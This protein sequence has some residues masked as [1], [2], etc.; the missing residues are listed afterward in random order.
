[1]NFIK[2]TVLGLIAAVALSANASQAGEGAPVRGDGSRAR[3][4]GTS[5]HQ[6]QNLGTS[7][8]ALAAWSDIGPAPQNISIEGMPVNEVAKSLATTF[9]NQFDLIL[10]PDDPETSA[11]TVQMRLKDAP[12]AE[13]F[14]AMNL[15]FQANKIQAQWTLMLNGNRPIAVLAVV[16]PGKSPGAAAPPVEPDRKTTVFSIADYLYASTP[17]ALYKQSAT[18]LLE[19]LE[20]VFDDV[21][22]RPGSSPHGAIPPVT[23]DHGPPARAPQSGPEGGNRAEAPVIKIHAEAGILVFIGTAEQTAL[24]R[25]TLEALT[26]ARRRK[27]DVLDRE[28]KA[29]LREAR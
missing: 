25:S 20:A 2:E 14:N 1:M 13:I 6:L 10:P 15:Y 29:N 7:D 22:S 23:T 27:A 18:N 26:D 4:E 5:I 12:A 21:S 24:V 8:A 16:H 19:G 11:I 17:S 9:K 28:Q 3:G